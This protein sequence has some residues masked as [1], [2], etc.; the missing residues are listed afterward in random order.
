MKNINHV[1]DFTS[2][3]HLIQYVS[4]VDPESGS[5][6]P[7]PPPSWRID[8]ETNRDNDVVRRAYRRGRRIPDKLCGCPLT[9][10][11]LGCH[12][13]R[14]GDVRGFYD[15]DGVVRAYTYKYYNIV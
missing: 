9:G 14:A 1:F 5:N 10:G 8:D 6:D 3:V 4:R 15:Y 13:N 11:G 2:K 12:R 7:S